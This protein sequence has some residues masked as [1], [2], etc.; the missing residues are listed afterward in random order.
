M[1][2]GAGEQG[3]GAT[4]TGWRLMRSTAP[5]RL[6]SPQML[7]ATGP[8]SESEHLGNQCGPRASCR[9]RDCEPSAALGHSGEVEGALP[10]AHG[11]QQALPQHLLG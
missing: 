5:G 9:R 6:S 4:E 2:A 11:V 1:T 3:A 8:E 7:M 10:L